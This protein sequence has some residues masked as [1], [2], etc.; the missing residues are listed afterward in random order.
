MAWLVRKALTNE[1]VLGTRSVM[2]IVTAGLQGNSSNFQDPYRWLCTGAAQLVKVP[3]AESHGTTPFMKIQTA[4]M[5]PSA[6]ESTP[7]P[8][9]PYSM[10]QVVVVPVTWCR[11]TAAKTSF[12]LCLTILETFRLQHQGTRNEAHSWGPSFVLNI[13]GVL[14]EILFLGLVLQKCFMKRN[15]RRVGYLPIISDFGSLG[16]MAIKVRHSLDAVS[17]WIMNYSGCDGSYGL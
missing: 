11:K 3:R 5:Y 1:S 12:C 9:C 7:P 6:H 17:L 4:C 10:R 8:G 2:K 13:P 14:Q 16:T 15:G